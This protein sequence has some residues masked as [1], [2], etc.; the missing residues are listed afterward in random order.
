MHNNINISWLFLLTY[1]TFNNLEGM[2]SFELS[3]V[4]DKNKPFHVITLTRNQSKGGFYLPIT[5][6]EAVTVFSVAN[7][8]LGETEELFNTYIEKAISFEQYNAFL[9]EKNKKISK[10]VEL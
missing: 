2:S 6:S 10:R 5:V 8:F 7:R 9:E 3:T 1:F 4:L